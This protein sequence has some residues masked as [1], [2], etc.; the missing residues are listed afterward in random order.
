MGENNKQ[1]CIFKV[2]DDARNRKKN[3]HIHLSI[4]K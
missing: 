2:K 1:M 3:I 4:T